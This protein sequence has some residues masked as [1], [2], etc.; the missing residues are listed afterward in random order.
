MTCISY[1][2]A[3]NGSKLNYCNNWIEKEEKKFKVSVSEYKYL[4]SKIVGV[5]PIVRYISKGTLLPSSFKVG[6][7]KLPLLKYISLSKK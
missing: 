1:R 7:G 6:E 2:S 5:N 3:G 4:W